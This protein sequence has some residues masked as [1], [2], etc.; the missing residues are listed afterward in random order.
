MSSGKS[1]LKKYLSRLQSRDVKAD[2]PIG[3]FFDSNA[4]K[5]ARFQAL[6]DA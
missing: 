5:I 3:G 1:E 6:S 2:L 4:T